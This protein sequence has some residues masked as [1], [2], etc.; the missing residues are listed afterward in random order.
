[1]AIIMGLW[2]GAVVGVLVGLGSKNSDLGF[3][4][5]NFTMALIFLLILIRDNLDEIRKEM[6]RN[7]TK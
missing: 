1:M 2:L 4:A 5:G 7:Q 3:A 6:K